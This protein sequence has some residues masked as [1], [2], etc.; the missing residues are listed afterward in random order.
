[1][2][3]YKVVIAVLAAVFVLMPAVLLAG[4]EPDSSLVKKVARLEARIKVLEARVASLE[5]EARLSRQPR[6][7]FVRTQGAKGAWSML[8]EGMTKADVRRILGE[9]DTIP[10]NSYLEIW[11]YSKTYGGSCSVTFDE[12]GK[13]ESWNAPQ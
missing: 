13:V 10:P 12:N 4:S 11:D 8:Q 2:K 7:S 5:R 1:M 3:S 6:A 9:P